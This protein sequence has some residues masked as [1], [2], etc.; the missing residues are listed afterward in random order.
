MRFLW[1]QDLSQFLVLALLNVHLGHCLNQC[2]FIRLVP[3][4]TTHRHGHTSI[5]TLPRQHHFSSALLHHLSSSFLTLPSTH[6]FTISLPSPQLSTDSTTIVVG[7][8]MDKLPPELLD[9]VIYYLALPSQT[10]EEKIALCDLRQT[11]KS[12]AKICAPYLFKSIP[13][14]MNLTSV[15]RLTD[16]SKDPIM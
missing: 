1:R 11:N 3:R 9:R 15:Q 10:Y 4:G 12:F 5:N 16:L 6:F 2:A 14:W 13:L 7:F 8:V